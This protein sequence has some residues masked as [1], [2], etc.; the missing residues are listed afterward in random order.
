MCDLNFKI[1][2]LP[3]A[4]F[5]SPSGKLPVIQCGKYIISEPNSIIDFVKV[6]GHR[7]DDHLNDDDKAKLKAY[8]SLVNSKLTPAQ[9][10]IAWSL[11]D[12]DEITWKRWQC[13]SMATQLFF[14]LQEASIYVATFTSH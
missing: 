6:K 8:M 4:E 14:A 2:Q 3:N 1:E 10:Y 9:K 5:I 12:T 13:L 7:L 11:D